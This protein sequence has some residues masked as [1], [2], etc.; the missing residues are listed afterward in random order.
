MR[1]IILINLPSPWLI[2]DTDL[3]PM[4]L[5]SLAAT[6]R[7]AGVDVQIWDLAGKSFELSCYAIPVAEVYGI[8]F[9]T[10]QYAMAKRMVERIRLVQGQSKIVLG[11]SHVSA[12]PGRT[13]QE[14]SPDVAFAG[15]ADWALVDYMQGRDPE[16]IPGAISF[17]GHVNP[18]PQVQPDLLPMPARDLLDV[19]K[20]HFL[21][22]FG[23]V[24]GT[25]EGYI[26]TARGCPYNCAFCGQKCVTGGRVRNKTMDQIVAEVR[27][28]KH[29]YGCDQI[30]IEDDTFNLNPARAK[31][32]SYALEFSN[33]A[34]HCLMRA[35][36][37]SRG[38]L[39]VM[40]NA[41]CQAVVFGFE[42]G[43]E[44]ILQRMRKRLTVDQALRAAELCQSVGIKV[45][46]QMI[47]GFPGETDE[48]IQETERFVRTA[49]VDKWG[50]HSF[51]P[52]PGSDVWNNPE[53]Y[54]LELDTATADFEHGFTTIGRP[55]EWDQTF[56]RK[57]WLERLTSIA[58]GRNIWEGME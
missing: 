31:Q 17:D 1:D 53:D 40:Y 11:G 28:L 10:P 49:A 47:V 56:V 13:V 43:S 18:L 34:W 39:E 33:M 42:S 19:D 3:P 7:E 35:D 44:S 41:G 15:E 4:G 25:R 50:F 58:E 36:R 30:Y 45:R 26:Q 6:L 46:A 8:G 54:G 16:F 37:V 48:T 27:V 9:V 14:L 23:Y 20:Y 5:M 22:T 55:G 57:E 29:R 32:I 24:G 51:V 38:L 12:L 2:S 52:L 21:D